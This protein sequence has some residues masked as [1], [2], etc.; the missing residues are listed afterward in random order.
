MP[1]IFVSPPAKGKTTKL[2]KPA[3]DVKKGATSGSG[4]F[5]A[6]MFMPE[7]VHF[8]TQNPGE[9]IILLLRKH[10]ITNVPWIITGLVLIITPIFLLPFLIITNIIPANIDRDLITLF[11]LVWYL[12][13][14]GYI[15]VEFL[16]WYFTV[17]IVTDER[18]VD[19]DFLTILNKKYAETRISKVEDVTE[20]KGGFIASLFDYGDV[21]VQTAAKEQVFEFTA[22]PHAERVVRIISQLLGQEEEEGN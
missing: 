7:G 2:L 17:S 22:A 4:I 21:I 5:S 8:A 3:A 16:L 11:I 20:R 14:A 18:I 9:T 13:T 10:F 6:Y 1:D 19:I 12:F 15:Y